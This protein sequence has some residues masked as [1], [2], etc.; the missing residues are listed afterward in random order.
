MS[1][2]NRARRAQD[3]YL[4]LVRQFPLRPIRSARELNRAVKRVDAL[5]S[6]GSLSS[7][8]EDYLDVL[9]D[10]VERYEAAAQP[11]SPVSDAEML[12]HLI[13]ARRVTQTAVAEATGIAVSTI[14]EVLRS[15]RSLNRAHIGKL[16]RYFKVSAEVFAF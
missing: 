8:E 3:R 10:L 15:K 1:T 9:G 13:E 11:M 4:D 14:S 6:K 5:L 7:E 12:A 16:A 2:V